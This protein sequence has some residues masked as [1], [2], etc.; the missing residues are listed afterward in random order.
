MQWKRANNQSPTISLITISGYRTICFTL[1]EVLILAEIG[2]L[3]ATVAKPSILCQLFLI[4]D[5][6]WDRFFKAG[7]GVVC[8]WGGGG[9]GGDEQSLVPWA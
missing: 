2:I 7:P 3:T 8:G 6:S 5:L 4:W 1:L 9:G